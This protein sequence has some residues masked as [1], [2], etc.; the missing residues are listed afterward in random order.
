MNIARLPRRKRPLLRVSW[1]CCAIA[2]W[3]RATT[4]SVSSFFPRLNPSTRWRT[5]HSLILEQLMPKLK[6]GSGGGLCRRADVPSHLQPAARIQMSWHGRHACWLWPC[7]HCSRRLQG[8]GRVWH[9][10]L[11]IQRAAAKLFAKAA[12]ELVSMV[13]RR[14]WRPSASLHRYRARTRLWC[15]GDRMAKR[16]RVTAKPLVPNV[17]TLGAK[18]FMSAH[19]LRQL[20]RAVQI[21]KLN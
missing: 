20:Q 1:P 7:G 19:R 11:T 6:R 14:V 13:C 3:T 2:N 18:P 15:N 17:G 5:L 10:C 9:Q 21:F 12:S 8:E 4:R 16:R